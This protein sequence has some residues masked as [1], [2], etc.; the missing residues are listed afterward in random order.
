MA[1]FKEGDLVK[2][3]TEG[4]SGEERAMHGIYDYM[5]NLRG[6]VENHYG[7]NEV[8]V[9][10]D[11]DSLPPIARQVHTVASQRMRDKFAES[12]GEE[13]RKMLSK[14]ELEFVPNYVILVREADLDKA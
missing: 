5:L 3:K 8:A 11:L 13:Q 4:M 2:V 12:V 7:V 10:I 14:D 9:K 6:T 1:R